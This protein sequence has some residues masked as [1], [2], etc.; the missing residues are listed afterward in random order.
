MLYYLSIL[1]CLGMRTWVLL[2]LNFR[3]LLDIQVERS[4]AQIDNRIT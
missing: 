3:C 2:R 4:R 1:R